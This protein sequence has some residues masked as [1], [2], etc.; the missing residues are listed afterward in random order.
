ME[1]VAESRTAIASGALRTQFRSAMAGASSR[2]VS[3]RRSRNWRFR[4]SAG[5]DYA[6]FSND[7]FD[8]D[9]AYGQPRGEANEVIPL[10]EE[11]VTPLC[12]PAIAKRDSQTERSV[13]TGAHPIGSQTGPVAAMVRGQQP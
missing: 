10:G 8:V 11:T 4:L 5:T 1:E 7:D 2:S 6:Q 13:R 9:V 3:C 12:T